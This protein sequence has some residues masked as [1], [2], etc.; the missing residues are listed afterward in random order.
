M[1]KTSLY[2]LKYKKVDWY[3]KRVLINISFVIEV[4]SLHA[5]VEIVYGLNIYSGL[6][7]DM[8]K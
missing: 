8:K 7:K 1:H 6:E 4:D 2:R 3:V 5:T